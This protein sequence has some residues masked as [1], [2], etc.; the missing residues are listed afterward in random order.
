MIYL[1]GQK[2]V[3]QN[4]RNFGL[5]SKILS[6]E[7]LSDKVIYRREKTRQIWMEFQKLQKC[8]VRDNLS[9]IFF[10]VIRCLAWGHSKVCHL[11]TRYVLLPPHISHFS[12]FVFNPFPLVT[13]RKVINPELKMSR[14]L[15][16]ALG[17]IFAEM[18]I[19]STQNV[20]FWID[21]YTK[22]SIDLWW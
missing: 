6:D 12:S 20:I 21:N 1:I 17:P 16:W 22:I 19:F 18:C 5:V 4:R 15:M 8:S 13:P 10:Y 7:I 11:K 9:N 3:S 2:L 14:N